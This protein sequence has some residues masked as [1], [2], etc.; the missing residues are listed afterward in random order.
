MERRPRDVELDH[1]PLSGSGA[2]KD[3]PDACLDRVRFVH[4]GADHD[5][6]LAVRAAPASHPRDS[7]RPASRSRR[8]GRCSTG[9]VEML[10]SDTPGPDRSMR[11]MALAGT[12]LGSVNVRMARR[13]SLSQRLTTTAAPRRDARP[14]CGH[15][16][17]RGRATHSGLG[18]MTRHDRGHATPSAEMRQ[19]Q[20]ADRDSSMGRWPD[21]VNE[22]WSRPRNTG[23]RRRAARGRA[24]RRGP[25]RPRRG[26]ARCPRRRGRDGRRSGARS[27]RT[28]AGSGS[29][30]PTGW[31]RPSRSRRLQAQ[32]E[33]TD[34]RE[35]LD[36][37]RCAGW[38]RARWASSRTIADPRPGIKSRRL[39]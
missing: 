12:S 25:P 9:G 21:S 15:R 39:R 14:W 17:C 27:S 22:P 3:A 1:G 19:H 29:T 2:R 10:A 7:G 31:P 20:V 37:A 16:G 4:V 33:A 26:R 28:R 11:S 18:Y 34:A 5:P 13:R 24:A 8:S 38:G 32:P 6:S 36:D 30:A 23:I 35:Q